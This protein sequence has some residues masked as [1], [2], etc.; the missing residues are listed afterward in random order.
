MK[1]QKDNDTSL[2]RRQFLGGKALMGLAGVGALVLSACGPA[3]RTGRRTARR[4]TRRTNRRINTLPRGYETVTIG[5][6]SYY[7]ANGAYWQRMGSG[8]NVYYVE[9]IVE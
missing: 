2:S 8:S 5:G 7:Y 6:G 3:R 4:V 9:V 1:E